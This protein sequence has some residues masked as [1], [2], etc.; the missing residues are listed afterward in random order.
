MFELGAKL[1][2]IDV[3]FFARLG[4][5][6]LWGRAAGVCL[7][8][9]CLFIRAGDVVWMSMP[10]GLADASDVGVVLGL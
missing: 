9:R 2:I 7:I 5:G 10:R 3:W 8:V 4:T 6:V 1:N